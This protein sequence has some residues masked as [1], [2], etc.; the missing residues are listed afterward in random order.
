MSDWDIGELKPVGCYIFAGVSK[1]IDLTTANVFGRL[2]YFASK[3]SGPTKF[4]IDNCAIALQISQDTVMRCIQKM[5]K[6]GLISR[7][8]DSRWEPYLYSINRSLLATWQNATSTP[9]SATLYPASCDPTAGNV[10][11]DSGSNLRPVYTD[12][13]EVNTEGDTECVHTHTKTPTYPSSS[14]EVEDVMRQWIQD[15]PN[16]I[17]SQM[18]IQIEAEKYFNK[19]GVEGEWKV[20]GK[21][22]N[23]PYSMLSAWIDTW[24][25][26]ELMS[27]KGTVIYQGRKQASFDDTFKETAIA[28]MEAIEEM[29][30][31]DYD[32]LEVKDDA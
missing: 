26:T 31:E 7:H 27:Q 9:Q 32:L 15:H 11:P 28:G 12:H 16:P 2:Y 3:N 22:M 19:Y 1:H 20:Y 30:N 14:R 29:E 24:R 6:A 18:D 4:F 10:R 25:R 8:R 23:D 21:R 17:F 13:T 5:L